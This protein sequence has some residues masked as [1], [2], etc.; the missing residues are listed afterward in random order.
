MNATPASAR[1]T[2]DAGGK[3]N[4]ARRPAAYEATDQATTGMNNS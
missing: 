4:P 2:G 3:L 1:G